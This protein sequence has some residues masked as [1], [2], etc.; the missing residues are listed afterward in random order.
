MA[1]SSSNHRYEH[2]IVPKEEILEFA[3]PSDH[4]FPT[5]FGVGNN[6]A[7]SS[8]S[9]MRAN[10][11]GMG[12]SPSLVD[13]V[14]GEK[15][16]EDAELILETL[17]SYQDSR[18]SDSGSSDSLDSLF[19]DKDASTPLEVSSF[20]QPKEEPDSL[21]GAADGK[22]AS[23][24]TM[25][26]CRDEVEFAMN[27][28]GEDAPINDLV[29]FILATQISA[30]LE[31]EVDTVHGDENKEDANDE[32]LY[33]IMEKS[34]RLLEMGFS[35]NQVSIAIEKFGSGAQ[36][37]DLAES[38]VTGQIY[39]NCPEEK[40]KC[41]TSH[42]DHS[43]NVPRFLGAASYGSVKLEN[44][45]L[46]PDT[47]FR[48]RDH[49]LAENHLGKRPKEEII[50]DSNS[51]PQFR[52]S[53]PID[54]GD[55]RK[56]KRPKRDYVDDL[57]SAWFEEKV[58]PEIC[59]VGNPELRSV[60]AMATK[61]PYF[62]YGNVLN[63]PYDSWSKVSQFLHDHQPEYVNNQFFSALNRKEG[64][65]H[66]LPTENRFRIL[67]EPPMTI[68]DAIPYAKNLWPSWDTRKQLTCV[69]SETRGISQ[70]CDRLGRMVSD[71]RGVLTSEKQR[72]ILHHSNSLN[73]VWVGR[74]RL[75]PLQPEYLEKILG[76]PLN[77]TKVGESDLMDR[78]VS[79]KY[80]FQTDTL[81]YH[82]SVLK[83][84]YPEGLT[85]FSIFSG[86]GGA[87]IALHKLGIP[88]KGV[89][90]VETC[91]TK[92]RI[93]RRWWETTG[94]SGQLEQIDD[95]QKLSS[96]KLE[97]LMRRFGGFDFL[98]CQNPCSSS[99]SKIPAQSDSDPGFDFSLFYEFV[100]VY[101]R[102]KSM[103]DRS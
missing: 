61:A 16:E 66:N 100:R 27:R 58:D 62:L 41:S 65:V 40:I 68:Q 90:S 97:S 35:E 21:D 8:G 82:L 72:E 86:I 29:D 37:T 56:G 7:S 69:S 81:A 67:E 4:A 92:R 20:I 48:S 53:R 70:L 31:N 38:I 45:E 6:D 102:V 89:V 12:F 2:E 93:L 64:Y 17:L 28:L 73:L 79:L 14:I 94:Q 36:L 1:N 43:H 91:A 59:K 51:V 47:T 54:F 74:N 15:G 13:R 19:G 57:S 49:D 30:K 52:V 5:H 87:E 60:N 85:M 10:M 42:S 32:N 46:Y 44:E 11:I 55:K 83:P 103:M 18:K 84:L 95:I 9:N 75:G 77:H 63:L 3:L 101:Q 50:D 39:N 23:L 26:F 71:C 76:Y 78:L 99:V 22:K 96:N 33:G 25:N 34:V 98:I 24:L 80:C 88:L